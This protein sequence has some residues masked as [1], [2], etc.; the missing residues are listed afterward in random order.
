MKSAPECY[1]CLK[2]LA[3][4]TAALAAGGD[5]LR[6]KAEEVALKALDDGFSP[7]T[8]SIVTASQIHRAIRELT[9]NPDPY[10]DMKNREIEVSWE[11]Y[12]ELGAEG[13]VEFREC[14]ELAAKANAIDFFRPL[15]IVRQEVRKPIR[16]AIDHSDILAERL[17]KADSVLYLADNAGEALLDLPLVLYMSKLTAVTYVVKAAP[18]QNDI[19]LED[20]ERAG[21]VDRFPRIIDTG[22]ATP[23]I[24][25]PEASEAFKA[26]F[27]AADIIF[28]KGMGY[29]ESLSELPAAGRVFHCLKA[30]CAPVARNID[31]PLDS[32]VAMLR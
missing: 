21:I 26:E 5:S 32:Y 16:F 31:V 22:T 12:R 18:T 24:V 28:A 17:E 29:Y 30:K 4:N 8:V 13:F 3:I 7:N 15:D 25:L 14:L 2:K 23:G 1:Q 10:R 11:L 19:T 20:I 27:K 9:G 6:A